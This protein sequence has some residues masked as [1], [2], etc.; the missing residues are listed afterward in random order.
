VITIPGYTTADKVP[1]VVAVNKWGAGKKSIGAIPLVCTL[2]GN[3]GADGTAAADTRYE[4][5]T[6]EEADAL[7]EP[8]SELARMAH[9]ALD[10]PGVTLR[11]VGVEPAAGGTSATFT[12]DITGSW[13]T[14]GELG[15]QIDEEVLRVAVAASHTPTTFG[16]AL[17][18]AIDQAQDGRLFCTAANTTGRV[19]LT[20]FS[21]G[22]R[23]NQHQVFLDTSLLPSGMSVAADQLSDVV[24]SGAGPAITVA[25]TDSVDG[26]YVVTITTG[27]ANGT[28]VFGV[29]RN[30]IS[31]AAGVTVPT[32]PFTY[33]IPGTSIVITFGNGT[34]VL[35]ETHTWTGV[36]ALSNGAIPFMG[37][38]GTDDI[39]DALESQESVTN[40]Y[41]GLAHNDA[42]NVGKVETHVSNKAAFDVGR[43]EQYVTGM[44]RTLTAA[45]ALGQTGM[46]DQ[47]GQC[48]WVQ[49]GMEH[50]S[51]VS[52]R[53]AALR[54]ITEGGQPNT[55]YD[56]VV[57]PGAAPQLKESDIPNRSTLNSAL[58]NSV[59]P[60]IT[61]DGDLQIVRSIC[62]R[63]LNGA[64][65]DYRTYDSGDVSVPIRVRKELV[66][67][68][69]FLKSDEGGGMKWD[70]PDPEEG[71]APPSIFT[72]NFW[73]GQCNAKLQEWASERFNWL[74]DV[75]E[76]PAKAEWDP[77]AKRT[78]SDVPTVVRHQFHQLGI[79]VRQTAA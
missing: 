30:S 60:L 69:Q 40:D 4:L 7:F 27:G 49:N 72:P 73:A 76:N 15:I 25:G 44:N 18:S 31:L 17:E 74:Q 19:V 68:G 45:I 12:I 34:H 65:P 16:D 2:Y 26:T 10:V 8:R 51:R 71:L 14:S 50:P 24:K 29:T 21:V 57:V 22:V 48:L 33:P 1:G 63:S 32:T 64:T 9:A 77:D 47:L 62:S 42:T 23:G 58:S 61:V 43:L 70:G 38:A 52:A 46:N 79:Q 3:F 67:H 5:T 20:V 39:E 6:P 13:S 37:G 78:M 75:E 11:C 54:S 55:N 36:A 41:I 59:T 53:M 66:A 28:A 35:N 56:D